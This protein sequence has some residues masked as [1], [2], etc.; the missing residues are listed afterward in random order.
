LAA[1][2]VLTPAGVSQRLDRL[3]QAKLVERTTNPRDRRVVSVTL[4][5]TGLRLLDELMDEYMDHEERL[6]HRL[7]D[8]ERVTLSRLLTKLDDS[9]ASADD[10]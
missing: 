6:L 4:T 10:R 3:E 7:S 2:L 5:S 8:R 9:I 1:S